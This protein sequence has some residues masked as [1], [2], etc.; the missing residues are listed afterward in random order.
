MCYRLL[1]GRHHGVVGSDD[2]DGDIGN[3]STTG[4]HGGKRLMTRSIKECYLASVLKLNVVCTD[5]LCDT[6]SLTCDN[7]CLA[8]IVEQ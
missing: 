6:T 1:G 2:D 8:Y 3:L 4:T 5:V 7:V